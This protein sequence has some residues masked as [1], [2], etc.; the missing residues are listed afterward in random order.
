MKPQDKKRVLGPACV[1]HREP[2]HDGQRNDCTPQRVPM[3]VWHLRRHRTLCGGLPWRRCR[4]VAGRARRTERSL[5]S[6]TDHDRW[7]EPIYLDASA[8][9]HLLSETTKTRSHTYVSYAARR[10]RQAFAAWLMMKALRYAPLLDHLTAGIDGKNHGEL[11][12]AA[13]IAAPPPLHTAFPFRDP[14][15]SAPGRSRP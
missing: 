8:H 11:P 4:A 2:P 9:Y 5:V 3:D 13:L 6:T 10:H 12:A 1:N 14:G 15:T 7:A